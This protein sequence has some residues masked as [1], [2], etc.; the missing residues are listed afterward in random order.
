MIIQAGREYHW[1]GTAVE[2]HRRGQNMAEAFTWNERFVFS[3]W[4]LSIISFV[5]IGDPEHDMLQF[6]VKDANSSKTVFP[7]HHGPQVVSSADWRC[8]ISSCQCA[9]AA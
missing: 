5:K 6:N 1:H 4:R 7:S 2:T 8:R 9:Y 3:V